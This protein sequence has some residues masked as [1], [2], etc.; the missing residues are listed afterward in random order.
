MTILFI[1]ES[2]GKVAKISKFLGKNYIVKAS[3][4]HFRDLDPN[5]MSIDFDNN[6]DPHY[7][8]T[9]PDVV[10]NLKSAMRNIEMVYI[11]T[12]SDFEGFAIAQHL[13]D[14]L[15][16]KNYKRLVFNSITKEAILTAIKNAGPNNKNY[17]DTQKARRVLDRLYGFLISPIL[18]KQIGGQLSAGRVQS[19]ATKIIIDKENEIKDFIEKN[20]D[21]TYFKVNGLFSKLKANLFTT[22]EP[23]TDEAYAG[24][25]A[26]I[27][28]SKPPKPNSKIVT[29]MNKCLKSEFVVHSVGDKIAIRNPSPPF[30][31]AT[32]QQEAS[33]KFGMTIDI[34]M[35]TAQKLYE[36]GY[37]TYM[38]TDSVEISPEGHKEIKAVIDKQYGKDYYQKNVYKNKSANCQEAHES[39]RP[40][41]PD[42]LS[43]ENEIDD[44]FQ[45][46]LYK[47]I[48]QRAIASQMKPAKINVTTIQID[49]SKYVNE[50]IE[51]FYYFQS[52]IEKVIFPGFMKVYVESVDD[53][54][55]DE[56]MRDFS[57]KIPKTGD[58]VLM[59]EIT[60]KQEYKKPPPRYSEASLVKT[61]KK[62]G[63]GRPS[64]YVN[65]I[66]TI[67]NRD[68][69]KV[70]NILGTK[71]EIT[72]FTIKSENKKHVMEIFE[73]SGTVLLGKENKKIIP[74]GLGITVNDFLV[75]NF[76][77]MMDY[78]FT[79]KMEE[80]LDAIS[81]GEKVWHKVVKKF[82]DKLSPIIEEL[83]KKKGIAKKEDKLL[84]E[85]Q[86]GNE[87]FA[88]KTKYGPAVKKQLESKPVYAKIPEPLTI[89]NIK[90]KDAIKLF[91]YPKVLGKHEN[92][93][94]MLH[95]GQYGF[96]ILFDKENYTICDEC[97]DEI[98]L[99][100]AIKIIQ[101]KKSS[102]LGQF[103]LT[104]NKTKVKANVLKGQYG[105][106]I[107]VIS[108]K[109][110][111]NY[112]VPRNVDPEKLTDEQVLEIIS[113][114][115]TAKKDA[116][117]KKPSGS[118]TAKKTP[119]KKTPA[120]K[121][122]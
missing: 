71:K 76:P 115:R 113:K 13:I 64:T 78:K 54:A 19:V 90:L 106:Y 31:T 26:H 39:V 116:N 47:L 60:A 98:N 42:L 94:V 27:A 96:Y 57:G 122:D 1:V 99:K 97:D 81:N 84:G 36:G 68:Y 58:E 16:P 104:Q 103:N 18:Q 75:E 32:L 92:K 40:I 37:I 14:V 61:L 22:D 74:T 121:N 117:A 20:V 12:D 23:N 17:V 46:K 70:G 30:E 49:I 111:F 109:K 8:I 11:A 69:V 79:A 102:I 10:K 105:P 2:P 85:D 59:E 51:P 7:V 118:K 65:T 66:K 9:K 91:E 108:G 52:Q 38:R 86:D 100:F 87:I 21:S 25:V 15:K 110:K 44:A 5:C 24:K 107:Q 119:V 48:W 43:L 93:E 28:L 80:E 6:F 33:R 53:A 67:M 120:K 55:D 63:I 62:L 35:K 101:A 95:K 112:P 114:K 29:F 82:Y 72:T 73:E 88:V 45:I 4:G 56:T 41:H 50:K 34:T 83:A 3:V 77:E 89:D